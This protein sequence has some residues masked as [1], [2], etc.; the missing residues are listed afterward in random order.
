MPHLE[1][2]TTNGEKEVAE[3]EQQPRREVP[4]F[5]QRAQVSG[6]VLLVELDQLVGELVGF[7]FEHDL[8]DASPSPTI[9]STI[10]DGIDDRARDPRRLLATGA[11]IARIR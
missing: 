10:S 11:A 1:A 5:A 8:H 7:D 6:A 3:V 2:L 9:V 4:L